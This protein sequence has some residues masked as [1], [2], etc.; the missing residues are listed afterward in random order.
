M[1]E[2]DDE[3]LL[4]A[5]RNRVCIEDVS[6]RVDDGRFAVKRIVGDVL[7]VEAAVFADGHEQV[8]AALRWRRDGGSQWSEARMT[9]L[10]DDR[11]CGSFAL[12]DAGRWWFTV[13]GWIDRF[14]TWRADLG[15]RV[16]AGQDVDVELHIGA[17]LVAEAAAGAEPMAKAELERAAGVLASPGDLEH[18]LAVARSDELA[19]L[20]Q[21]WDPRR[22]ATRSPEL[23]VLVERERAR[24]SSWYELFPR[25]CGAPG[26]H[27]TLRDVIARLPY[28]AAMGFDVLYLPPIHPI[29]HTHRK[30]RNNA[31][32]AQ[33]GDPGSPWAIGSEAGGHTAIHPR[34]GT[35]EDF[36][37]LRAAAAA[38]GIELALDIAFQASPDHPWVREH[39]EFFRRRPDG[40]IQYAENPPKV[41][42]DIYPIDFES[43]HWRELWAELLGV[44]EF[45]A[46]RGVRI[47]RVDNP[48]TKA[49]PFWE[50]CIDRLRARFPDV[51]LLSEAFTRPRRMY[52]LA[53][54]GFSQSYTYFTWRNTAWS[55]RRYIEEI[56]R[57]PV[58][59]FFRPNLWPNTPD[60]LPEHLQYGGRPTF[61]A[62]LV[63][64][65]T[66][67]PSWGIYGP[68]FELCEHRAVREGSEEYLDSEKY[69]LRT[70][71]LEA[72]HSLAELVALVNRIRRENPALQRNDVRFLDSDNDQVLAYVKEA[73]GNVVLVV[74]SF[75]PHH[76]QSAWIRFALPDREPVQM[77]D[78]L[79]G[80]RFMWSGERHFVRLD[81]SSMPAHVFALRR[82]VRSERDFDYFG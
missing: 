64:A 54:A 56:T 32:H 30:G 81:P 68:A 43:E 27:G 28:I 76:V 4:R 19:A 6:P 41:Y 15:K 21:R 80:D 72:P 61:V 31:P 17:A 11:F 23:P 14:A 51:I 78:L 50:W 10:V 38:H 47:F 79:A 35:F 37:A 57:P 44:F 82:R 75:D 74:V 20:V 52:R 67:S 9:A 39:P 49:M 66:L 63:L 58:S 65:A 46:A 25:S 62:R 59:E 53:K 16:A 36:E 7:V 34:L 55:M 18:R 5:G 60:I 12:P 48:H 71:D 26:E 29:G 40:T 3:D 77:H 45:W 1:R 42:Q 70:W 8:A 33:P 73:E 13:E 22:F 24:F 2:R 69:Q